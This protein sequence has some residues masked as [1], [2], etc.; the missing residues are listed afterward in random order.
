[1]DKYAKMTKELETEIEQLVESRNKTRMKQASLLGKRMFLMSSE[2]LLTSNLSKLEEIIDILKNKKDYLKENRNK[3]IKGMLLCFVMTRLLIFID[4]LSLLTKVSTYPLFSNI[5]TL[6]LSTAICYGV[7][8]IKTRKNRKIY[9][10]NNLD[11]SM[12]ERDNI[13]N[14]LETLN[15]KFSEN[16]QL[17]SDIEKEIA[18][19]DDLIARKNSEC[20][21][22]KQKREKAIERLVEEIGL[23]DYLPEEIVISSEDYEIYDDVKRDEAVLLKQTLSKI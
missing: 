4:P 16:K 17:N 2:T 12:T 5:L 18:I 19:L 6:L 22:I 7:Y 23:D 14:D 13:K 10:N 11:D 9:K 8:L 1:M 15:K 21:S 3:F 20:E